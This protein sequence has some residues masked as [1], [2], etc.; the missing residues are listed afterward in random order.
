MRA[1]VSPVRHRHGRRQLRE[2]PVTGIRSRTAARCE[3]SSGSEPRVSG[4]PPQARPGRRRAVPEDH[5]DAA[6]EGSGRRS[7]HL[8]LQPAGLQHQREH[9]AGAVRRPAASRPAVER[10]RTPA[11]QTLITARLLGP[12]AVLPPAV[13]QWNVGHHTDIT[14]ESLSLFYLLEP[15]I[16]ILVLGTGARTERLDP[17]VLDFL[18]K[19]GI[20]VEVQDTVNTSLRSSGINPHVTAV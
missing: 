5:S 10:E 8:Q 4:A 20:A 18:K 3:A 13:L 1:L 6:A 19:K 2:A 15:R 11:A 9:G 12:C 16:E 14:V 17:N 7:R